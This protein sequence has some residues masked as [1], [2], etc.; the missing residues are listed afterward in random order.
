ME[1]FISVEE[2]RR[3]ILSEIDALGTEYLFL[4]EARGRHI[5]ETLRAPEDSPRFDNSSRDGYAVRWEDLRDGPA[6]L[7]LVDRAVAGG[8]ADTAVGP[9]EAARIATGAKIPEGADTVVMQEHCRVD[10]ETVHVES[11]PD[12]GRGAWIRESGAHMEEGDVLLEPGAQ[13][14]AADLG[15]LAN[16]RNSR[17]EVYR[18]PTVAVVSTGDELVEIDETPGEGEIVNSNAHLLQ[19]LVA[20]ADGTATLLPIAPDEFEPTRAR[21]RE[22]VRAAD[23]VVSCGGVSVGDRDEVRGVVDKLTGGMKFW[24]VRMKP[25]KPLAFGVAGGDRE[26]P[27]LGLPGNPNSCFVGFHQFA[28]PVLRAMQGAP[29]EHFDRPRRIRARLAQSVESTPHRRHY[30]AG[31]LR[32]GDD[33]SDPPEFVPAPAQSSGNVGLFSGQNAFGIVPEETASLEAGSLLDVEP[34]S[35]LW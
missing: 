21:F 1:T 19:A 28:A 3:R 24:K 5:A 15:L 10:G 29:T 14:G 2:A 25:G 4:S 31:R 11:P 33:S 30:L 26:V 32:G 6:S 7:Q 35:T 9:G 23:L 20:E 8:S 27:I 17:V 16:F 12:P 22:A 18:R 34:L 13:L